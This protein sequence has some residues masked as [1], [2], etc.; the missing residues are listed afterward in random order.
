MREPKV[1]YRLPP[2]PEH[3][4]EGMESWLEDMAKQG[5]IL[6]KDSFFLGLATF[7]KGAP[8]QIQYRLEATDTNGG[9]FSDRYDPKDEAVQLN[10]QMGWHYRGRRGQFHIYASSDPHVPELNTDPQVQAMTIQA[11]SKYLRRELIS[12]I[13]C[14]LFISLLNLSHLAVSACVVL[15]TATVLGFLLLLV[16]NLCGKLRTILHL[17]K[18]SGKLRSG[19]ALTHRSDYRSRMVPYYAGRL[20]RTVLTIWVA[21][22]M[23]YTWGSHISEANVTPL[24]THPGDFPFA[25]IQDFYPDAELTPKDG[26]LHSEYQEYSDFLSPIAY[27]YSEYADITMPDGEGFT[28]YLTVEYFELRCEWA[29]QRLARELVS[30]MGGNPID[31]FFDALFGD[32][33]VEVTPLEGTGAD[34]AVYY[35][36]YRD[37][38]YIVLQNGTTVVRVDLDIIGEGIHLPFDEVAQVLMDSIS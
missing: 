11:L 30:Q 29:A 28:C 33:A 12:S 35:Y 1:I 19:E 3:D 27:D 10:R 24:S 8:Q 20:L 34:Y 17:K 26:M 25:T 36:R 15:G 37:V 4:I 14:F 7:E 18:V 6:A 31:Q 38:P 5:C 22:S 13:L 21:C 16:W 9:L 2:C 32:D 23:V